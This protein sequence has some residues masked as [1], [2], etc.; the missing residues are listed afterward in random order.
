MR[1]NS[2][3]LSTLS[4][5]CIA[6]AFAIVGSVIYVLVAPIPPATRIA[7]AHAVINEMAT[8]PS[9]GPIQGN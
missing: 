1:R 3:E 6:A 2:S 7:L 9:T 5:L 4:I 8:A